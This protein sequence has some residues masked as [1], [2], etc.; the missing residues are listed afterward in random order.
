VNVFGVRRLYISF[1]GVWMF[2]G[3]EE[4]HGREEAGVERQLQGRLLED[5]SADLLTQLN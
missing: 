1:C 4:A 3:G 2:A 5:G